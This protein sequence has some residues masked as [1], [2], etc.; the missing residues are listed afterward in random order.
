MVRL[1]KIGRIFFQDRAHRFS[2]RLAVKSAATGEHFVQ[3]RAKR[4]Y[5]GTMVHWPPAY[6]FGRHVSDSANYH[7]GIS[8]HASGRNVCL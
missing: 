7:T 4:E 2:R 6:L 1:R 5:V 8:I 3:N